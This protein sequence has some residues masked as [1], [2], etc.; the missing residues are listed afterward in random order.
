MGFSY[1]CSK[2]LLFESNGA[3]LQL[4]NIQVSFIIRNLPIIIPH[5]ELFYIVYYFD[6][7]PFSPKKYFHA[8]TS[9]CQFENI[10]GSLR[11]YWFYNCIHLVWYICGVFLLLGSWYRFELYC[12][13]KSAEPIR[14]Q[15]WKATY[16]HNSRIKLYL[17]LVG[18][19]CKKYCCNLGN[20][21]INAHHSPRNK[22][23]YKW[24][25]LF[26]FF[27]ILN[28]IITRF[29]RH[30]FCLGHM[31]AKVSVDFLIWRKELLLR[32][33]FFKFY[34]TSRFWMKGHT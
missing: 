6:F 30:E 33:F 11:L 27:L 14:K 3:S 12:L 15:S 16:I 17:L 29:Y 2:Y 31:K 8:G 25:K 22:S 34:S 4:S 19:A 26:V 7:W 23:A 32:V 21:I 18:H 1:K 13:N 28:L 24:F 5:I 9:K 10:F 20:N